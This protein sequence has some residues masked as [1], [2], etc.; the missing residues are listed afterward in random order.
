MD[1][2]TKTLSALDAAVQDAAGSGLTADVIIPVKRELSVTLV[3]ARYLERLRE[4]NADKSIYTSAISLVV[5]AILSYAIN[6]LTNQ[7]I[8]IDQED[9]VVGIIL[10]IVLAGA[11]YR[12]RVIK[13]RESRA[14]EKMYAINDIKN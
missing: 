12:L 13:D 4:I 8:I 2:T 7:A 9:I 5:G 6:Q 14:L 11:I 1:E 3:D 10:V